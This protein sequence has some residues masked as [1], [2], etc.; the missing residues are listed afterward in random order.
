MSATVGLVALRNDSVFPAQSWNSSQTM[1]GFSAFRTA[2]A[3]LA[4]KTFGRA[5]AVA[6]TPQKLTKSRRE[7]PRC[8]SSVSNQDPGFLIHTLPSMD[9]PLL[10]KM[11]R[12]C[13][14]TMIQTHYSGPVVR[15]DR[16]AK[17][18]R[19]LSSGVDGDSCM[20]FAAR[21]P[22]EVTR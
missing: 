17:R 2:S 15:V 3:I 13:P 9:K 20:E 14:M 8:S 4:P 19:G 11:V 6:I 16:V 10:H 12:L 18:P 1:T 7:T 22:R 21:E 5:S